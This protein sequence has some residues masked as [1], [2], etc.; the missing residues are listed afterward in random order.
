MKSNDH[1]FSDTK[2]QILTARNV[3]GESKTKMMTNIGFKRDS[4]NV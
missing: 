2:F 4:I 3:V 1:T